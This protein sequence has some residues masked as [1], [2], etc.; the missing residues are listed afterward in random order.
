MVTA[1]H[2]PAAYNGY[3]VYWEN[4]AQLSAPH[5]VEIAGTIARD[6]SVLAL[7]RLTRPAARAAGLWQS[8]T[9]LED[10]YLRGLAARLGAPP[11]PRLTPSVAYTALHGVGEPLARAALQLAGVTAIESVL[12]QAEPDPDFPSVRFPNPEEPGTTER[13][14]ALAERTGATLALANDPD[15][16]RLAA[17]ARTNDGTLAALSGNELGLLLCDYL[18]QQAPRDGRNLI[19]TTLVSTPLAAAV[20]RDHAARLE[21]TLTGFKWIVGRAL[22]LERAG[23]RFVL[24]FEE[25]IGYCIGDL[26]R[27]KDGIAAAAHVARMSEWYAARSVDQTSAAASPP[28]SLHAALEALYR[29]HGLIESSQVSL[30]VPPS[31][32]AL[33]Q[34]QR[35]LQ[36]LRTQPLTQ[37]AGLTVSARRDLLDAEARA[38]PDWPPTDMLCFEL[39]DRHRVTIRPSGTEPK[40]KVYIDCAA[41]LST[42]DSLGAVRDQLAEVATQ[43]ADDLRQR[44]GF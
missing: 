32:A 14:L 15:A 19:V 10:S 35:R 5:D 20:A 41:R 33:D 30:A 9:G 25:A 17:M 4:G 1:S 28:P 42:Q 43:I 12:E 31:A 11:S 8:L 18:L 2:N 13:V 37:L 24:G 23:F 27:D 34:L 26:V 21:V 7:P 36:Q 29:K 44:L 16:D 40:I 3:K 6:A 38:Q 22:E 39:E